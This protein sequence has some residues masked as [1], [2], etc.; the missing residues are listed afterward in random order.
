MSYNATVYKVMIA[1]PSDVTDERII[2]REV[3]QEWNSVHSEDRQTVLMP[4]GWETDAS[5]SMEDRPQEVI[6]RQILRNCD[7]LVAA[8]WTRLG[9]PT[10]KSP[11]GTVEEIE[12]HWGADKPAMIY[13]SSVP[14]VMESV[15]PEQ[16]EA[17][18]AFKKQ[19]RD[20]GLVETYESLQEFREKFSRQLAQTVI[21]NFSS[22][23]QPVS[24]DVRV[25]D[26][27]EGAET[28]SADAKELF[29]EAVKDPHG[30]VSKMES[31]AG[32][33]VSTNRREFV[34]RGNPRS[35]AKWLGALE[36]LCDHDLLQDQGDGQVF[37]VTRSGYEMPD[38]FAEE[39][40]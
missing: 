35:E 4:L 3:I 38:R 20:R 29:I 26:R 9:S 12:E 17:L 7:L 13:F 16:W 34:E 8:F 2:V 10:G 18:Q 22:G 39:D 27:D 1:S 33:D 21:R 28:L 30:Y 6:S 40:E 24:A 14:V 36:E 37:K 11:S 32:T 25:V 23:G 15:E 31:L 19:C 5:P